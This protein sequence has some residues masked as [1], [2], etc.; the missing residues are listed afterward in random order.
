MGTC[1]VTYCCGGGPPLNHSI[2]GLLMLLVYAQTAAPAGNDPTLCHLCRYVS[3][4]LPSLT[5][6][7]L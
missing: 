7:I 6:T 4:S 3:R 2:N 1:G 5:H